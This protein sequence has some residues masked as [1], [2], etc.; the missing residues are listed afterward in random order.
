MS[1]DET[2]SQIAGEAEM[3]RKRISAT[4]DELQDRL[5]PRRIVGEAVG[6][7]QA[8][9]TELLNT[10]LGAARAHPVL[11]ASAGVAVGLALLGSRKLRGA[12]VNFGDQSELYS[13]YDDDYDDRPSVGDGG[14]ERFALLRGANAVTGDNALIGVVVGLAVGAV[15]GALF[16]ET[17]RE[18]RLLG[19]SADR[20]GAAARTAAKTAREELG[21]AGEKVADVAAQAK[22]A[23]QSVVEAAK[24]ELHG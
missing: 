21:V 6:S 12:K 11:L 2:T 15:I 3:T 23:V 13:D 16:P 8:S 7:V 20:L 17:E 22:S 4:I 18:R 9:G 5:N 14:T 19:A 1:A 24:S 10:G